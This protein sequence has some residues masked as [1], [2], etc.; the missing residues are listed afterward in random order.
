MFRFWLRRG[1]D[2]FRVDAI[3]TLFEVDDVSLDEPLSHEP[4]FRQVRALF[5]FLQYN[6]HQEVVRKL[7]IDII[8]MLK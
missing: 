3:Q 7:F 5:F 8:D 4:G 1:V 2:G 6:V